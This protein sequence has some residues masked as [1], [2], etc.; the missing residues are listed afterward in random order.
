MST[1][2][3][4][5]YKHRLLVALTSILPFLSWLHF[6]FLEMERSQNTFLRWN[7]VALALAETFVVWMFV[8]GW[9][10]VRSAATPGTEA[11]RG[12]RAELAV[13]RFMI[14]TALAV[15]V[16]CAG[17]ALL[18]PPHQLAWAAVAASIGAAAAPSI[19]AI[20]WNVRNDY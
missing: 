19:W 2:P 11:T 17:A 20:G 15:E 6:M 12:Q 4:I 13:S 16:L 14:H 1:Q 5:R 10:R 18:M 3:Q 8:R 7:S 9:I